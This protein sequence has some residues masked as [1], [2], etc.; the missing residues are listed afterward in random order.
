[1]SL[2]P[3]YRTQIALLLEGA[4]PTPADK[5]G[6]VHNE[7]YQIGLAMVRR[8]ALV[9]TVERTRSS[10]SLSRFIVGILYAPH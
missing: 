5:T 2:D 7:S 10:G 8:A 3:M 9:A 4:T 1:M 6:N